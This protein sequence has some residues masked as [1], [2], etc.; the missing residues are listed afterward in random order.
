MLWR[1]PVAASVAGRTVKARVTAEPEA[2]APARPAPAHRRSAAVRDTASA[3]VPPAPTSE[4]VAELHE[5]A[6]NAGALA[7]VKDAEPRLPEATT[8]AIPSSATAAHEIALS[9]SRPRNDARRNR[10]AGMIARWIL[11]LRDHRQNLDAEFLKMDGAPLR[12]AIETR[13]TGTARARVLLTYDQGGLR[14]ADELYFAAKGMGSEKGTLDRVLAEAS[15]AR[16][17]VERDWEAKYTSED[18]YPKKGRLPDGTE[19]WVAGMLDDELS[20]WSE[21]NF[22]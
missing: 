2:R 19:S 16:A 13:L 17:Q 9:L 12:T 5:M 14:L 11:L 3:R 10:D 15:G 7:A 20:F 18:D 1:L 22:D 6:G 4:G 21:A 8:Q